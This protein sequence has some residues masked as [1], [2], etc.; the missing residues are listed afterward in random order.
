MHRAVRAA[1]L[2]AISALFAALSA[3]PPSVLTA[4]LWFTP[5]VAAQPNVTQGR[6]QANRSSNVRAQANAP[7]DFSADE[8][9]RIIAIGPWPPAEAQ[10]LDRS[11]RVSQDATAAAFGKLLFE[12]GRLSA[13]GRISCASCHRP[14]LAF[15]DGLSRAQG[16]GR[17]DR[18][19]PTV[20]NIALQRWFGW[21]GGADSLWSASI[22]PILASHE[23]GLNERQVRDRVVQDPD[24]L[25]QYRRLFGSPGE[26]DLVLANIGKAIASYLETLW[27][28]PTAFDRFRAA[29]ARGQTPASAAVGAAFEPAAQRGLRTFLGV[30]NCTVCHVG[31]HFSNG[32]FH[33]VARPFMVEPGRVDPGRHSG[34][35]RVMGDRFNLLGSF[36]DEDER[37]S[38]ASG[39]LP[40]S[41]RLR[42]LWPQH[43]NWGEWRTPSLRNLTATAPYMHDGS[44]A[45]LEAVVDHYNTINLERL[46][47]DG[48][49]LLKPLGLDAR[50]RDDLV[51]FLRSL[52]P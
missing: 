19:T 30:G 40:E 18:N 11:N 2:I 31:A 48:E 51:A 50:E 33:D 28:P 7:V 47:A 35:R 46:H 52:S 43:R 37:Q 9:E 36:N 16:L 32:E 34:V 45:T 4:V 44:L 8:I 1:V 23:M 6:D 10:R 29:L 21:D 12:S 5:N 24:W 27:S 25:E 20:L 39:R 22:R 42:T 15:T 49:Q 17:H 26:A 38:V 41:I 14:E 13:N 3:A